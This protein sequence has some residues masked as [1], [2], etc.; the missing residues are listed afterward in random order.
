MD[1]KSLQKFLFLGICTFVIACAP[2]QP[3]NTQVGE[4]FNPKYAN[5]FRVIT[6]G[7]DTLLLSINPN[8]KRDIDTVKVNSIHNFACL[9]ATHTAFIDVLDA[10]ENIRAVDFCRFHASRALKNSCKH[11]DIIELG[12]ISS[13]G[14]EK[15]LE[16]GVSIVTISG[17]DDLPGWAEKSKKLNISPTRVWEWKEEHPLGKAEWLI[18]FGYLTGKEN[19]ALQIFKKEE[20]DYKRISDPSPDQKTY[21]FSGNA[22][23]GIWYCPN[24][25]SYLNKVFRKT[26]LTLTLDSLSGTA[27][28]PISAEQAFTALNNSQKW[29][30]HGSCKTFDCLLS[31]EPRLQYL[32]KDIQSEIWAPNKLLAEDGSNAFWELSTVYPSRLLEDFVAIKSGLEPKHFYINIGKT[33]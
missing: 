16:S 32:N 10:I 7:S 22:Y 27:S 1:L 31:E 24:T 14:A 25:D 4:L 21:I 19:K 28:S 12:Q 11:G 20:E 5:F 6:R 29:I 13:I 3:D 17:F 18:A 26:G 23:Q 15:I 30:Y 8:N 33:H 2:K 9:S